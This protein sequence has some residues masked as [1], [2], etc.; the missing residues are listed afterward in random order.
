MQPAALSNTKH[1]IMSRPILRL[2]YEFVQGG[3]RQVKDGITL[4]NKEMRICKVDF[5]VHETIMQHSLYNY[6]KYNFIG[7]VKP[8]QNI[9]Y[10]P[11]AA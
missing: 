10:D 9:F 1:K 6:K 7:L 8:L 3:A 4:K 2:I 11:I 5:F